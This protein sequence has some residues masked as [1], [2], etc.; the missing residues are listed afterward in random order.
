MQVE[1]AAQRLQLRQ[2]SN[3]TPQAA[4]E[5]IDRPRRDHIDLPSGGILKQPI[6]TR[7]P[8]AALPIVPSRPNS[9]RKNWC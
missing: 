5:A 2:E 3:E 8:V 4:P 7:T 9:L 6:E 1:I